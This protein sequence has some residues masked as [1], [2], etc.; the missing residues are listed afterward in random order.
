MSETLGTTQ[1][2][3]F[4]GG[5]FWCMEAVFQRLKGVAKVV[6]GYTGGTKENPTYEEVSAGTSGHAEAVQIIFDPKVVSYEQLLQV[7]WHLHDPTTLNQQGNDMGTQ[8]RSVIFYHDPLQKKTAEASMNKAESSKMYP[9][10]FVTEIKP[11]TKFYKAEN[12]HQDYFNK[13]SYQP[14]CQYVIDPKITKLYKEFKE[15]TKDKIA[16]TVTN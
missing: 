6:S 9:G 5:C 15:L 1:I 13:N 14:Y 3:T 16:N 10:K 4:A 2:A 8:Y 12:Y 11:F 7:F